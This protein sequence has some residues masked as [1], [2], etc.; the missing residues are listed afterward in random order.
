MM[1]YHVGVLPWGSI[2]DFFGKLRHS[3]QETISVSN[4]I[5]DLL[6]KGILFKE[7]VGGEKHTG[8]G[9]KHWSWYD[10]LLP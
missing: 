5:F 2:S 7:E 6:S 4:N 1:P 9:T 3:L 10:I 8:C